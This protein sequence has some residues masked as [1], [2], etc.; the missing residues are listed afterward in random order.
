ML[1]AL[2]VPGFNGV[3]I[4][5]FINGSLSGELLHRRPMKA[6]FAQ[7]KKYEIISRWQK[8]ILHLTV[9]YCI[10]SRR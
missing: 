3:A 6:K 8:I 4:S 2:D 10:I 7:N 1:Q 5:Q 9:I